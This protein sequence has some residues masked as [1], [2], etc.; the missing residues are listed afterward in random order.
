MYLI[1]IVILCI[2]SVLAV[3]ICR[4]LRKTGFVC[5]VGTMP[6]LAVCL[7]MVMAICTALIPLC[8]K[9]IPTLTAQKDFFKVNN[10]K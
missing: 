7:I 6:S 8:I 10:N 4:L 9:Y 2:H 1:S 5:M 3:L